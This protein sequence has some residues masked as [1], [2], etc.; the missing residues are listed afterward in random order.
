MELEQQRE[1]EDIK[2]FLAENKKLLEENNALLKKLHRNATWNFW[3]RVVWYAL[4]L[5]L[6]FAI[7]FMF[8]PV[9]SAYFTALG[10]DYDKF[11]EGMLELPGFKNLNGSINGG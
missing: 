3:L 2:N 6:P 8:A 11:Q 7:Y 9:F 10:S 1:H 5:G 4:L